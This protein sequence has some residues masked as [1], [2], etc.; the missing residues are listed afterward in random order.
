MKNTK[1]E[2]P[3]LKSIINFLIISAVYLKRIFVYHITKKPLSFPMFFQIQTNNL[4][5]GSCSMCP[6]SKKKNK[7]PGRMSNELFEKIIKE[8]SENRL[9]YTI[10][11]LFLQNEPLTDNN[12]FNKLKLVKKLSNGK[13]ITSIVTNGT[14]L[15]EEKIKE[16]SE[17]NVDIIF[18][19]IDAFTEET[20]N[21]IRRGLSYNQV[22]KNIEN[23]INS[24]CKTFVVVKFTLQ[25]D[26]YL[27]LNDFK[28][29]WKKKGIITEIGYVNNR[30]GDVSNFEDI[31]LTPKKVPFKRKFLHNFKLRLAG[32]CFILATA[33]NILYNGDVIMCCNDYSKRVILGNVKNK[34]IK[35]IWN[36]KKYNSI[37]EAVSNK[38]FE[39]IPGCNNC[40]AVRIIK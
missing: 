29:F 19:S 38:D 11:W 27:E 2:K 1:I 25:K 32:G 33:F 17:A 5:N 23:I 35:D 40:T 4:C 37:R 3:E 36:S 14:L 7:K 9:T 26:N 20:Y 30:L 31:Y 34:T 16:L 10:I 24:N 18:F 21:K 22:L 28:K 8:I 6:L 39:K 13:I 15:T 12:I